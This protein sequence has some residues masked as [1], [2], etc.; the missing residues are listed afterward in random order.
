MERQLD[1]TIIVPAYNEAGRIGPTLN[2]VLEYFGRQSYSW[3]LLVVDDGS[4]DDTVQVVRGL[5]APEVPAKIL[6]NER[7]LGK[8]AAVRRGALAAQGKYVLFSDADL[9]TPIEEVEKLLPWLESGYDV[10]IGSRRVAG[11]RIEQYQPLHRRILGRGFAWLTNL[12]LVKGVSD[13]NC[14]FK[15]FRREAAQDLFSRQVM[16]DWSFDAEVLFIAQRR[17]YQ[18]K[19]VPVRWADSRASKVSVLR[20]VVRSLISLVKIRINGWLGRY[21]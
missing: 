17:G 16:D 3:E 2:R 12:L 20:D 14:G 1:L 9:A 21:R 19:E 18:I 15:S 6:A 5:L 13:I 8:G 4:Q 7:N 10:V 11:S